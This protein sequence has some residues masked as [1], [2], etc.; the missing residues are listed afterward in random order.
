LFP[1]PVRKTVVSAVVERLEDTANCSPKIFATPAHAKWLMEVVAQGFTLHMEDLPIIEKCVAT[2]TK[3]LLGGPD[4]KPPGLVA[5]ET[6]FR[7]VRI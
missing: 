3:W 4:D 7:G 1:Y 6:F 2:Y 5:E